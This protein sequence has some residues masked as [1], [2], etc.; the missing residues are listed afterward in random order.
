MPFQSVITLPFRGRSNV[1]TSKPSI[2]MS[3]L[4][5]LS[6]TLM[7]KRHFLGLFADNNVHDMQ[8]AGMALMESSDSEIYDNT[9]TNVKYGIRISV[10]GSS[11][12]ECG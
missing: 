4:H 8:D 1:A 11:D 7:I 10:G 2:S 12:C 5:V 9:F 3:R 6:T